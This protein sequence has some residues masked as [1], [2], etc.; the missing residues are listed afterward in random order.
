[1]EILS[2]FLGASE[3]S[4]KTLYLHKYPQSITIK[5]QLKLVAMNRLRIS[6]VYVMHVY[7]LA[8]IL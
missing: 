2:R 3:Q 6:C 1:M 5:S 7:L 4:D 8:C